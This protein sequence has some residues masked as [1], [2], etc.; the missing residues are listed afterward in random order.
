MKLSLASLFTILILVSCAEKRAE[1]KEPILL[2]DREAPLGWTYLRIFQDS[3]FE[4]VVSG[5]W[6]STVYSGKAEIDKKQISFAYKDSIPRAGNVAIYDKNM[7]YY[8]HGSYPERLGIRL[9]K[10]DS[11]AYDKFSIREIEQVIQQ[12]IDLPALQKCFRIDSL[13]KRK[14]LRIEEFGIINPTTL[15]GVHKFG[16]PVW[17]ISRA[18]ADSLKE[19][20]YLSI[21][22]WTNIN[23]RLRFQLH[24][25][26]EE[27]TI[28]YL[29][30]KDSSKW[31]LIDHKILAE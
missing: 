20:F 17:V 9:S 4:F 23:D 5:P 11:S 2:A 15:R 14:P 21:G 3:T 18:Q 19:K 28:G 22:D 10:I 31:N 30:A 12:A 6:S 27:M 24:C 13:P 29:F 8:T 25:A 26:A 7:V 1:E 16:A